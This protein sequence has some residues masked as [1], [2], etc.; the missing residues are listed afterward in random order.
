MVKQICLVVIVISISRANTTGRVKRRGLT[1][2]AIPTNCAAATAANNPPSTFH[3]PSLFT[4]PPARITKNP[5]SEASSATTAKLI[6]NPV[7]RHMEQ[8]ERP[9]PPSLP[10]Q[11]EGSGK[12][13][14]E[15]VDDA[16]RRCRPIVSVTVPPE[17][18]GT[19]RETH[20][21]ETMEVMVRTV[22]VGGGGAGVSQSWVGLA[23]WRWV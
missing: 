4:R 1:T 13:A 16:H 12:G 20:L 15:P 7:V 10:S 17:G 18:E 22:A 5:T 2:T 21:G 19:V 3:P 6:R 23:S 8:K 9:A 11:R 14:Q